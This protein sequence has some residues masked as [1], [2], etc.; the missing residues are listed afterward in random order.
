[1]SRDIIYYELRKVVITA[2]RAGEFRLSTAACLDCALCGE[3]IDGMG[4]PG[5]A[6][7]CERCAGVVRQGG[8]R[9]CIKWGLE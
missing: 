6:P 5:N 7:I 1:M 4:G 9:G 3:N 8:A 2:V